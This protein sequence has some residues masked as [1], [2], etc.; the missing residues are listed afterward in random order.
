MADYTNIVAE[1]RAKYG[2]PLG[3]ENAWKVCNAVA[4]RLR[5]LT[6]DSNWGLHRKGGHN[7]N[8]YATDIVAYQGGSMFDVL[9]D[10]ENKG[11]PQW[12]QSDPTTDWAPPVG[13]V[14]PSPAP[15]PT[16]T[17][18]PS[19]DIATLVAAINASMN[20]LI[21]MHQQQLAAIAAVLDSTS[22]LRDTTLAIRSDIAIAESTVRTSAASIVQAIND[23]QFKIKF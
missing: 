6:G 9:G 22:G 23:K 20:A 11:T 19:G 2:T 8:G 21:A 18:A 13:D 5:A 3:D 12:D 10:A 4:L 17:P 7:F 16:P 1:E 14:V 15:T